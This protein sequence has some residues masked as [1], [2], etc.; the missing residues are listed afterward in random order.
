MA[1][2]LH[3]QL[4]KALNEWEVRNSTYHLQEL[5]IYS[6]DITLSQKMNTNYLTEEEKYTFLTVTED[7]DRIVTIN[8]RGRGGYRIPSSYGGITSDTKEGVF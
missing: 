6:S 7:W 1:E 5:G 2:D 4:M 3:K 8:I